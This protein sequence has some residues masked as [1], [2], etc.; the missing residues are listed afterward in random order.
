[1]ENTFWIAKQITCEP[2]KLNNSDSISVVSFTIN[3][4]DKYTNNADYIIDIPQSVG[5]LQSNKQGWIL[6]IDVHDEYVNTLLY[7]IGSIPEDEQAH[8]A[9]HNIFPKQFSQVAHNRWINGLP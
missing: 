4:L 7:K 5:T 3:V 9:K 2:K 6:Q 1:M 8:F